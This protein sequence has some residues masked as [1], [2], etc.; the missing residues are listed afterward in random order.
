MENKIKL[1][2][3]A[4]K[5]NVCYRTAWNY[6]KQGRFDGQCDV[7]DKGSIFIFDEGASEFEQIMK[8]LREIK[9]IVGKI[10]NK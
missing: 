7:N 4:K 2:D 9:E 1:A 3:W 10:K 8:S 6:F 5:N